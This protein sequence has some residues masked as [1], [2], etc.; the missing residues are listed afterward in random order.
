MRFLPQHRG[1]GVIEWPFRK[2]DTNKPCA[3]GLGHLMAVA[4]VQPIGR[5]WP[6]PA[7]SGQQSRNTAKR[8][9]REVRGLCGPSGQTR[10]CLEVYSLRI[11]RTTAGPPS[12][13]PDSDD[14]ESRDSDDACFSRREEAAI[15]RL[16]LVSQVCSRGVPECVSGRRLLATALVLHVQNICSTCAERVTV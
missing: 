1:S 7:G 12:I 3:S 16:A 4:V 2:K 11:A 5:A 15:N 14:T 6:R 10:V 13:M 8:G 9:Q